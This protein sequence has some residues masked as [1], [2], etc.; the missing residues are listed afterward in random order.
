MRNRSVHL[1]IATVII[2]CAADPA[3][4]QDGQLPV[5][6]IEVMAAGEGLL[7]KYTAE[8]EGLQYRQSSVR[9]NCRRMAP[10][11]SA[12]SPMANTG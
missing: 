6:H 12:M 1:T 5:L 10:C 3:R 7:P 11:V 2:V 8:L 4:P 9:Q